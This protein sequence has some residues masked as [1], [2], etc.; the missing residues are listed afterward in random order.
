MDSQQRGRACNEALS[1]AD[2][3]FNRPVHI[4]ARPE[5]GEQRCRICA[6]RGRAPYGGLIESLADR[7]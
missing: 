6:R 4:E 3:A 5:T 1:L 7:L 2:P